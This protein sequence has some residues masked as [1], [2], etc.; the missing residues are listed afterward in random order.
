MRTSI[1]GGYQSR[2]AVIAGHNE[3]VHVSDLGGCSDMDRGGRFCFQWRVPG[4]VLLTGLYLANNGSSDW[5]SI[6]P[7]SEPNQQLQ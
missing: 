4:L 1:G 2:L 3:K 5:G 6:P 7:L